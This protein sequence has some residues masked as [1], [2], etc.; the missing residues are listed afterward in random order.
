MKEEDR[1][2]RRL[3]GRRWDRRS[4]RSEVVENRGKDEEPGAGSESRGALRRVAPR[5]EEGSEEHEPADEGDAGGDGSQEVR[6]ATTI[7]RRGAAPLGPASSQG[8]CYQYAPRVAKEACC[9]A[10]M[11]SSGTGALYP[12]PSPAT[13]IS[14]ARNSVV[15]AGGE[16]EVLTQ[17]TCDRYS[18]VADAGVPLTS[19]RAR[20]GHPLRPWR[21]CR[22]PR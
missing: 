5:C 18:P 16:S 21:A 3:V 20:T 11:A 14:T 6:H 8:G 17:P 7:V 13:C 9:L 22:L 15:G 12:S 1:Q 10:W 19:M 4:A 2:R